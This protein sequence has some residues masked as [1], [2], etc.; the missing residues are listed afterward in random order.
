MAKQ[1]DNEMRGVLFV[2]SKKDPKDTESKSPDFTGNCQIE[3]KEWR[4][5]AWKKKSG[6]GMPFISI[7]VSEPMEK[8]GDSRGSSAPSRNFSKN[9]S[10]STPKKSWEDNDDIL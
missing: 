7:A 8:Q 1:F 3:G 2:N 10:G 9:A 6:K 5:S 4:L